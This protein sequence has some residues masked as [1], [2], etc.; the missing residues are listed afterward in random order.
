MGG[1]VAVVGGMRGGG[2][3]GNLWLGMAGYVEILVLNYL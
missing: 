2:G 1:I 3:G